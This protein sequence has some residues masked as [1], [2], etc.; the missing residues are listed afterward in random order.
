MRPFHKTFL[1]VTAAVVLITLGGSTA[2]ARETHPPATKARAAATAVTPAGESVFHPCR[3][4][5]S[6]TPAD[7]DHLTYVVDSISALFNCAG[8]TVGGDAE[9]VTILVS[10]AISS[11]ATIADGT[12]QMIAIG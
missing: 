2:M 9:T 8:K 11:T 6:W 7:V 5:G 4:P 12:F 10:C 1:A 3:P